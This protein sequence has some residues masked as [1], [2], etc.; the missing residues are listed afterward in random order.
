MTNLSAKALGGLLGLL[1][2]MA[3]LLFIPAWTLNYGRA[4]AF[5]TMFGAATLAITLYLMKN[6]PKLLERRVYAGP[7]AEKE[8]GQQIVQSITAAG[9]IAGLVV[10]AGS[11]AALVVGAAFR[12]GAIFWS[13]R[14]FSSSSSCTR[15]TALRRQPSNSLPI[16]KSFRRAHMRWCAIQC[17]WAASS[18]S[19]ASHSR[20]AHGGDC[21]SSPS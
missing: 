4:W 2:V 18:C 8:M 21:S 13:R 12:V 9:F 20:S 7:S 16:R 14:D 15:K 19:W 10:R 11:P 17:T 5:L 1:V 6:D 3:A